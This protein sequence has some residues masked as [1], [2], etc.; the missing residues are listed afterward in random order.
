MHLDYIRSFCRVVKVKSITKAAKEMHLSQPALSLQI[1][2]LE[3]RL[4]TK[5]LERTN[6]GVKL[7]PSGELLYRHG[8]RL[9]KIVDTLERD[10]QDMRNPAGRS[11]KIS[12]SPYPGTY[13]LPLKILDF[14]KD[15][16]ESKFSVS[17]KPM[18]EVIESLVDRTTNIGVIS[19]P[20]PPGTASI[21]EAEKISCF[22]LSQDHIVAVCNRSSHWAGKEYSLE[23]LR[24]LPL[25]LLNRNYGSRLAIE[26]GL[27]KLNFSARQLNIVLELENC[28]AIVSAVK[29]NAGI[30]LVPRLACAGCADLEELS[31]PD[32]DIPVATSLLTTAAM[33]KTQAVQNLIDFL[34][35]QEDTDYTA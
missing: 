10:L 6:R 14:A 20:L 35:C 29:A 3:S 13:I 2:C 7:T 15:N 25:V 33:A 5:L 17:I 21:L 8:Q 22:P 1:N 18:R 9:L 23:E 26:Q 27:E 19:G 34:S 30:G 11:L 31:V 12:A 4:G 16:P 32:L 28:A 24:S